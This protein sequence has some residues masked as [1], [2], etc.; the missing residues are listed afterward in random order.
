VKHSK[1]QTQQWELAIYSAPPMYV[2]IVI[3]I[4][5][6]LYEVARLADIRRC[7]SEL[8][9]TNRHLLSWVL[10]FTCKFTITE[11]REMTWTHSY[12]LM[13]VI[14]KLKPHYT[15]LQEICCRLAG[16]SS[17]QQIS[18]KSP[19][20]LQQIR[21]VASK[22]TASLQHFATNG[23]VCNILAFRVVA[24]KSVVSPASLQQVAS[25]SPASLQQVYS[26]S[27]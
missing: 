16:W 24:D 5:M 17:L 22:S 12:P 7:N 27:V 25:K 15:D 19:A 10:V 3:H 18:S 4:L 1:L 2:D 26:K 8:K 6:M 13:I 9:Q 11:I 21:C 20:N 14:V 23:F